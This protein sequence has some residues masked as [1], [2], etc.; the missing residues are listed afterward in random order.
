MERCSHIFISLGILQSVCL[1]LRVS[2]SSQF[3][4][5]LCSADIANALWSSTRVSCVSGSRQRCI[6]L[7]PLRTPYPWTHVGQLLGSRIPCQ[8]APAFH[9]YCFQGDPC[10][11][12]L[13]NSSNSP[14]LQIPRTTALGVLRFR[15]SQGHYQFTVPC[16]SFFFKLFMVFDC[17]FRDPLRPCLCFI[18]QKALQV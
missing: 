14:L 3:R 9:S 11:H 7:A 15:K 8:L 18:Q 6:A 1:I 2:F 13:I 10:L 12:T 17:F 16:G 4:F 5:Y